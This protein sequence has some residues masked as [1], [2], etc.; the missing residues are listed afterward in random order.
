MATKHSVAQHEPIR[1]MINSERLSNEKGCQRDPSQ[2]PLDQ[3]APAN[4]RDEVHHNHSK[5]GYDQNT[6]TLRCNE[7]HK[8]SLRACRK[9]GIGRGG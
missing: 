3:A 6:Y 1:R 4:P 8:L 5:P 2:S 7:N 9:V